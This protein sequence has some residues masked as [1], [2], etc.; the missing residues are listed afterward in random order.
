[1]TTVSE[2][3]IK[4]AISKTNT[5]V[6]IAEICRAQSVLDEPSVKKLTRELLLSIT[7]ALRKFANQTT[8]VK[9]L[10]KD[11]KLEDD[12]A[13]KITN[14]LQEQLRMESSQSETFKLM[15]T[16]MQ[17][18]EK[19]KA[20]DKKQ[21]EE[22]E[23]QLVIDLA[24]KEKQLAIERADEMKKAEDKEKQLAIERA[25]EKKKA[26]DKE[27][28]LAI[29]RAD[30]KKKVEDKEKQLSLDK[31]EERKQYIQDRKDDREFLTQK[32]ETD[33]TNLVDSFKLLNTES[34]TRADEKKTKRME[35][36]ARRETKMKK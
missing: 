11:F 7:L 14:F 34:R 19:Q 8:P 4:V 20:E 29:E 3:E 28:Q 24:D 27:R 25:D 15:F 21:A 2:D 16:W 9:S 23:K 33:R 13:D 1:M 17:N 32:A 35:D 36:D 22:K 10:L 12:L 6:L 26:E 18:V 5:Q 31:I 30:E